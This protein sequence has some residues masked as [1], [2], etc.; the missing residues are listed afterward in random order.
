MQAPPSRLADRRGHRRGLQ[1]IQRRLEALVVSQRR[2]APDEA[3]DLVGRGL[4]QPR[5][6]QARVAGF[7]DLRSRP[8]QHV[9]VPNRGDAVLLRALHADRHAAGL[10][11]DGRRAP[12]LCQRE[13]RKGHQV[14]AVA[15]RHVARQ[16]AEQIELFALLPDCPGWAGHGEG[17]PHSSD[18]RAR[19]S[20]ECCSAY[21]GSDVLSKLRSAAQAS[22]SATAYMTRRPNLRNLGP[23]PSTRCFSSVR[24]DSRR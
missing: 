13:E 4:H 19:L 22:R 10:E 14:L 6:A 16:G 17:H 20:A 3:Q 5:R 9:R 24:G 15:R 18:Q 1:A 2:T 11:V 23:P 21:S 8:D 7:H 12:R